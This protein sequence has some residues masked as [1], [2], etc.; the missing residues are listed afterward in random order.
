MKL[1][2]LLFLSHN[3]LFAY[4]FIFL[5]VA[6]CS[7]EKK[8]RLS[9]ALY[10]IAL[11]AWFYVLAYY[12]VAKLMTIGVFFILFLLVKNRQ[13]LQLNIV[14]QLIRLISLI[15]IVL[16]FERGLSA[17]LTLFVP[18]RLTGNPTTFF[19]IIF[20]LDLLKLLLARGLILLDRGQGSKLHQSHQV[21]IAVSLLL[22]C[23]FLQKPLRYSPSLA[24]LLPFQSIM[25]YQLLITGLLV[26]ISLHFIM[27][28]RDEKQLKKVQLA[29]IEQYNENIERLYNQ[30]S[31]F[32]HDYLNILYSMRL[33]IEAGDMEGTRQIFEETVAP[34]QKLI[35]SDEFELGKLS[36]ISLMEVK[37]ILYTKLV[38][39]QSEGIRIGI[40]LS[41]DLDGFSI[42]TVL[43]VR[44]LSIL[45]DNAIQAASQ[46]ENKFITILLKKE[47]Q[48]T[49]FLVTNS[50]Q[51]LG[52]LLDKPLSPAN[53]TG[54]N[55]ASA[56]DGHGLYF[57]KKVIAENPQ[58]QLLTDV[59]E[60]EVRQTLVI[61]DR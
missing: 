13:S 8:R 10:V 52:S 32:R 45:L 57:V 28:K 51:S 12:Q 18:N 58:I 2:Q 29:R 23:I 27:K 50:C 6:I 19:M 31:T 60:H 36:Q 53:R 16:L 20:A 56:A 61:Q 34:T 11:V 47:S 9:N 43:L 1:N 25:F 46:A 5:T 30:L 48:Q 15:S 4:L 39:A 49:L 7:L 54:L 37:S 42:S 22:V 40:E 33:S 35:Q 59:T 38:K 26:I 44:L 24:R 41:P 21:L 55:V 17:L 3:V 14:T